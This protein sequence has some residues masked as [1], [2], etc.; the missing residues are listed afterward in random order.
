METPPPNFII[1]QCYITTHTGHVS[2]ADEERSWGGCHGNQDTIIINRQITPWW[3][4]IML[5]M[6]VDTSLATPHPANDSL[7]QSST[8]S[9]LQWRNHFHRGTFFSGVGRVHACWRSQRTQTQWSTDDRGA[10]WDE[11]PCSK[12]TSVGSP[13][14]SKTHFFPATFSAICPSWVWCC[15]L[16]KSGDIHCNSQDDLSVIH[17]LNFFLKA[18]SAIL[19]RSYHTDVCSS[20]HFSSW[21][22]AGQ[23]YGWERLKTTV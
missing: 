21:F 13:V 22:T 23:I 10:D 16:P 1:R 5:P 19:C 4:V 8:R 6:H 17:R 9:Q 12:P 3:F 2:Q 11:W 14:H 7:R 20:G 15:H 18:V